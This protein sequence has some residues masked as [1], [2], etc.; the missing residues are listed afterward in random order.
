MANLVNAYVLFDATTG[1]YVGDEGTQVSINCERLTAFSPR[2]TWLKRFL[3][4]GDGTTILYEP[5]FNPTSDELLDSNILPGMFISI[6]GRDLILDVTTI[7]AFQQA[8]DACCGAVPTIIASVYNGAPTA[9]TTLTLNSFCI[10]RNDDGSAGSHNQF[11]QD[12]AGNFVGTA[13]VR[14]SFS[15]TTHYTVKSYWSLAQYTSRLYPGDVIY[16][17][18]CS[19]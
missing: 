9:F 2:P 16:T 12:Y 6:D 10:Y 8:C 11:A 1:I 4:P 13:V 14:S 7:A 5:T 19:S 15:N 17:G 3:A 18:A